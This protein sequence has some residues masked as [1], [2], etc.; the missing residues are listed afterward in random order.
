MDKATL[1]RA[2]IVEHIELL[3]KLHE[4]SPNM[5]FAKKTVERALAQI[6]LEKNN[7]G[8]GEAQIA[9]WPEEMGKR[10]RTICRHTSCIQLRSSWPAWFRAAWDRQVLGSVLNGF[11][12]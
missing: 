1:Q 10:L 9:P 3:R 7:F 5:A 4:V 6:P 11:K 8:L 12:K 2:A